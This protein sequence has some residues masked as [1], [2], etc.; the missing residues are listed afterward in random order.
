[1]QFIDVKTDFAFKKVFGSLESKDILIN[2]LNAML[3]FKENPIVDLTIVNPYQIPTTNRLKKSSLH[4]KANLENDTIVIIDIQVLNIFRFGKLVLSNWAKSYSMQLEQSS[5]YELNPV[6]VLTISD[7]ILFKNKALKSVVISRFDILEKQH[8]VAY[9]EQDFELVFVELPKFDQSDTDLISTRDKWLY[10]LKYAGNLKSLPESLASEEAIQAA[11]KFADRSCFTVDEL[12]IQE[13][14]LRCFNDQQ[15]ILAR[16][17]EAEAKIALAQKS[18]AE[19]LAKLKHIQEEKQV[20]E[21]EKQAALAKA[22]QAENT[23]KEAAQ[24]TKLQIA[25]QMLQ[26]NV[27]IALIRQ[28]LEDAELENLND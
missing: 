24:A 5:H 7:F 25:K 21:A 17:E 27:D 9:L 23:A 14:Q 28:V 26:A 10:F 13:T 22:E 3:D 16:S 1:M 8:H 6:I 2:F 19:I 12:E 20:L 11:F 4:V 15:L 18:A